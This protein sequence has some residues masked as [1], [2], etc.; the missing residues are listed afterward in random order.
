MNGCNESLNARMRQEFLNEAIFTSLTHARQELEAS[1]HDHNH[2]RPHAHL[3]NKTV[4]RMGAGASGKPY[5]GHP[6]I[7]VVANTPSGGK[8]NGQRLNL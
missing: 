8:G 7:A 6:P 5:W 2:S 1:R 4:S 3:G